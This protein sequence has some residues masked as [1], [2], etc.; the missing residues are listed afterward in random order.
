MNDI[1]LI[2]D[3]TK[4]LIEEV[5]GVEPDLA[6]TTEESESDWGNSEVNW[7]LIEMP[8]NG[9]MYVV[10]SIGGAVVPVMVGIA[11]WA[12]VLMKLTE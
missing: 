3:D 8:R 11:P 9:R 10:E 6:T 2:L 5:A 12:T 7:G 4:I 1:S